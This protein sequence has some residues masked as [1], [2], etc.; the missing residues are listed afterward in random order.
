ML[1]IRAS[2]RASGRNIGHV[3]YV[4]REGRMGHY[5]WERGF[6]PRFNVRRTYF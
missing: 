1:I 2:L 5:G 6:D 3:E 4:A